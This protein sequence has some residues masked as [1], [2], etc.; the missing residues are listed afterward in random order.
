[1]KKTLTEKNKVFYKV[2]QYTTD[3]IIWH[4]VKNWIIISVL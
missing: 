1:M 3:L 2:T 4:A